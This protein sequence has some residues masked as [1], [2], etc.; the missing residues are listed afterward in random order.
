MR[1]VRLICSFGIFNATRKWGCG[2]SAPSSNSCIINNERSV[3]VDTTRRK[4]GLKRRKNPQ[5]NQNNQ[6]WIGVQRNFVWTNGKTTKQWLVQHAHRAWWQIKKE[7]ER[8]AFDSSYCPC[9]PSWPTVKIL[10][11]E[12]NW[13]GW[14]CLWDLYGVFQIILS[15]V[16]DENGV[17][18]QAVF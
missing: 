13:L 3:D 5:K 14:T 1:V 18:P 10:R 15:T 11:Q 16:L 6:Q 9:F 7:A 2:Q 17:V 8:H 12:L 4:C